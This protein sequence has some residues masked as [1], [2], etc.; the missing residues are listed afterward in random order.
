MD[1]TSLW[2]FL[3]ALLPFVIGVILMSKGNPSS[4][5]Y[6]VVSGILALIAIMWSGI[7]RR[8]VELYNRRGDVGVWVG[9]LPGKSVT[10]LETAL[11]RIAQGLD[12][13]IKKVWA[14]MQRL[15]DWIVK[16]A[17]WV[18]PRFE[19]KPF[20]WLGVMSLVWTGYYL[21]TAYT[22]ADWVMFHKAGF[23]LVIAIT[24]L[25]IHFDKHWVVCQAVW[26]KRAISWAT[27]SSI[28]LVTALSHGWW[29]GAGIAGLSL[30][31]A[32]ITIG[33]WWSKVG[34]GLAKLSSLLLSFFSGD[35]GG[36]PALIAWTMVGIILTLFYFAK[37]LDGEYSTE[38]YTVAS[39]TIL[40]IFIGMGVLTVKTVGKN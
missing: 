19:A 40:A 38:L 10:L 25:V 33:E 36:I 27:L 21:L 17:E 26:D 12:F 37:N 29:K 6:F 2:K 35:K 11:P 4:T 23:P 1:I 16:A 22:Q 20:L 34:E 13:A 28:V 32:T 15:A 31:C 8:A 18:W 7:A 30:I 24:L 14:G 39:A 9:T 3:P 5:M